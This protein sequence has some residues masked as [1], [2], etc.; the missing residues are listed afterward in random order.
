[1][2]FISQNCEVNQSFKSIEDKLYDLYA[3]GRKDGISSAAR[4][5]QNSIQ[6]MGPYHSTLI[7]EQAT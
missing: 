6:L 4:V 2:A 5:C 3:S 1:M 7:E